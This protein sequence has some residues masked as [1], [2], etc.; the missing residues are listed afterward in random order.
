M[1]VSKTL[2]L[3][4]RPKDRERISVQAESRNL[5]DS[6]FVKLIVL[7]AISRGGGTVEQLLSA[8]ES[9]V[10]EAVRCRNTRNYVKLWNRVGTRRY[11]WNDWYLVKNVSQGQ[12]RK[13]DDPVRWWTLYH[14]DGIVPPKPI[15]FNRE[16]AMALAVHFIEGIQSD[17]QSN[18]NNTGTDS[19]ATR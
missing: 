10:D 17:D 4:L 9:Q 6:A 12:T 18:H 13:Q 11:Q 1:S 8:G 5:A 15:N 16:K 19:D 7:G 3:T 14:R 2:H